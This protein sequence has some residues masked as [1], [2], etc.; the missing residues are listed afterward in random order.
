MLG[1]RSGK[2]KTEAGSVAVHRPRRSARVLKF[3]DYKI[4][5]RQTASDL[6]ADRW[7]QKSLQAHRHRA[8][9]D[10]ERV[11]GRLA[12][13]RKWISCTSTCS[14]VDF[15]QS[16]TTGGSV[17]AKPRAAQHC[18]PA[19]SINSFLW[20]Q[21]GLQSLLWT[22]R[23][24][25]PGIPARPGRG[26]ARTMATVIGAGPPFFGGIPVDSA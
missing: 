13:A 11:T 3:T 26:D 5:E 8:E 4:P 24:D 10:L 9:T 1:P 6:V 22:R 15:L 25:R 16:V 23:K 18:L 12:D 21:A 17:A 7:G 20:R 19:I 2:R 14:S